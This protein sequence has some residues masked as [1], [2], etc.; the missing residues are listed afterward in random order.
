M[1]LDEINSR[2][3]CHVL[4]FSFIGAFGSVVGRGGPSESHF[5]KPFLFLKWETAVVTNDRGNWKIELRA[6]MSLWNMIDTQ[7]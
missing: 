1:K 7:A 3:V 2:I 5:L 6:E 4:G